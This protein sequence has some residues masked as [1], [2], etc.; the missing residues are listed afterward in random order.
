[1]T[2]ATQ[3]F[4]MPASWFPHIV[5]DPWVSATPH[6]HFGSAWGEVG[7]DGYTFTLHSTTLGEWNVLI[8]AVRNDACGQ[9]CAAGP[10]EFQEAVPPLDDH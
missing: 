1:M 8:T 2:S 5:A 4:E 6:K 3:S 7:E 9:M 10:I